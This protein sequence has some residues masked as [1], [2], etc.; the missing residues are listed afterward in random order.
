MKIITIIGVLSLLTFGLHAEKYTKSSNEDI[1]FKIKNLGINVKG[2]FKSVS[3][4][5]VFDTDNASNISLKG[6]AKV[7]SIS[8]GIS[9]RDTHL[10]EKPEFFNEAKHPEVIMESYKVVKETDTKYTVYW[11]ITM[12]G[13]TKNIKTTMLVSNIDGGVKLSS[14]FSINRNTWELGGSSL[15]MGDLVTITI[16]TTLK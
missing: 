11:K 6:V 9:L 10:R 8:T 2:T 3:V 7:S 5:A 14:S 1:D 15:T 12:R 13:V 16:Q 4:N